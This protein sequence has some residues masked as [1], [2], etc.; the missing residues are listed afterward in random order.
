MSG[1]LIGGQFFIDK[2]LLIFLSIQIKI[3][4]VSGPVWHC[5]IED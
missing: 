1:A 4:N 3:N 2:I 5:A